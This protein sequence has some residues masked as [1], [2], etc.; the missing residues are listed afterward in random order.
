MNYYILENEEI[1]ESRWEKEPGERH[2]DSKVKSVT[3]KGEYDWFRAKENLEIEQHNKEVRKIN[4]QIN[5]IAN[6]RLAGMILKSGNNVG[7]DIEDTLTVMK[8]LAPDSF[9]ELKRYIK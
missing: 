9:N 8:D 3:S 4:N 6:L 7:I 1:I 2:L 5:K